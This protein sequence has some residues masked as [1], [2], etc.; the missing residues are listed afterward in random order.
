VIRASDVIPSVLQEVVRNAPLTPEKVAFAWRISVGPAVGKATSV[1]LGENGL[2]HVSCD[3]PAWAAAVRKSVP[4]IRRRLDGLLG[5]GAVK[6]L[7]FN[8]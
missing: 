2:L 1:R 7:R 6:A 8:D 4:L 5:A 3:S